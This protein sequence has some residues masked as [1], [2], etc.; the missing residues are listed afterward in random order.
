MLVWASCT[1]YAR[2][3]GAQLPT[4]TL[5]PSSRLP[6][7][8]A[9]AQLPPLGQPVPR[10]DER[11][12][13]TLPRLFGAFPTGLS[14]MLLTPRSIAS[15]LRDDSLDAHVRACIPKADQSYRPPHPW[16]RLDS[17]TADRAFVLLQVG[18]PLA[19]ASPCLYATNPH[20]RGA[21]IQIVEPRAKV[22]SVDDITGAT[23]L[24]D[25][26]PLAPALVARARTSALDTTGKPLP[27]A[28]NDLRVY[29][30][31]DA[32]A[33]DRRGRFPEVDLWL[34][35]ADTTLTPIEVLVSDTVVA[36]AWSDLTP[37]RLARL[38]GRAHSAA[39]PRLRVPSDTTLRRAAVLYARGMLVPA[40]I[41]AARGL[42]R[43]HDTPHTTSDA[44][45]AD[46]LVGSVFAAYGDSAAARAA[47]ASALRSAPCLRFGAH[48]AFDAQLVPLRPSGARCQ[49]ISPMRQ[50]A[51]GLV[52]PGGAQWVRGDRV[53]AG[54]AAATT[55]TLFVIAAQREQ[56]A[57]LQYDAYRSAINV[58]PAM[59]TA[60]LH[61]ANASRADA[62]AYLLGAA[63]V[64]AGSAVLGLVQEAV[65]AWRVR[66]EQQYEP[67]ADAGGGSR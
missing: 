32:L 10:G 41:T 55:A 22:P 18:V 56:D 14:T 9:I 52:L 54:I 47:Y 44:Q 34:T 1:S 42:E 58:A 67:R 2:T 21:D 49:S 13:D 45:F 26:R 48:P 35:T 5:I 63:S 11:A 6:T 59:M 60:M 33:P 3:L 61:S 66:S 50:V 30:A 29:L 28:P 43:L 64:W 53:L 40:A 24:L 17:V 4:D 7:A 37:W 65:H 39:L 51:A 31:P 57:Q 36:Q 27:A 25:G 62:R 16:A 15:I 20:M 23:V 8:A 38:E 46:L 12:P 19:P